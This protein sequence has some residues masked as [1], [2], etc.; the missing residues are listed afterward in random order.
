MDTIQFDSAVKARTG[1]FFPIYRLPFTVYRS[2]PVYRLLPAFYGLLLLATVGAAQEPHVV[3]AKMTTQSAAAGLASAFHAVE[4]GESGLA[5]IGYAVPSVPGNHQMCCDVSVGEFSDNGCGRCRLE[6]RRGDSGD[7]AVNSSEKRVKLES[8]PYFLVLY[9]IAARKV[10]KVRTFSADCELDVGGLP[11]VWLTDVRPPESVAWLTSLVNADHGGAPE[12]GDRDDDGH[13]SSAALTAIALHGDVS[14]E[15]ALEAFAAAGQ[16]ERRREKAAFWLGAARG[17]PGY[18]ALRRLVANDSSDHFREKAVFA[19]YVSKEPEAV[20][21]I[22]NV[23]HHDPAPHVRGQALFWLAQKAGKRAEATI[24]EAIE[25]DPETDV[26]KK[27]VFAL[28]QLPKDEGVPLLIQVARTSHNPAVRKQA[29]F[30]LG[31]SQDPR[32]LAF[33]E[34]VLLH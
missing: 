31:Q 22:I 27:A 34:Q 23:A 11:F 25:N 17:R 5:W 29:M 18:E 2:S 6:D 7:V 30:W 20:D 13:V 10:T 9:R 16:P 21:T 28:S 32:A 15:R 14:A 24:T 1:I 8:S 26:K 12:D 4:G 19:L 33:F 3:N